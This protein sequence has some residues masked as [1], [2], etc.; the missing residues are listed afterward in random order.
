[1][2]VPTTPEGLPLDDRSNAIKIPLIVLIIFSS[3]FVAIRLGINWRNRN[4]FLLTDHLLWTGHV[5]AIAGGACCYKMAEYGGGKHVWDPFMTPPRLEKQLYY[6]WLS[7]ILNLYGM[8]LVKLSVCAYIFMLD[9]SKTFRVMIWISIVVHVGVNFVFPTVILFGE[10]TPYSK[11]WDVAGT[12]PGSCWGPEPRVISGYS[13]A[14]V[15]IA[16]DLLYTMAPLVYISRI[17]LSKRTIW[18]VRAVFLC[19]LVTTTISALKLYEMKALANTK[20]PSFESVNLSIFASAE[21]FVGAFTASLPPLR[22]TFENFLRRILP[23]SLTGSSGKGSKA[24]RQSYMLD[25]I[26]ARSTAKSWPGKQETDGDSELGILPNEEAARPT[27][28]SDQAI[29]KTTN[30]TVTEDDRSLHL[31]I[32]SHLTSTPPPLHK[33]IPVTM[34]TSTLTPYTLDLSHRG[35]AQGRTYHDAQTGHPQCHYFGGIPYALPAARFQRA[36]PLPP[37]YRYGTQSQPGV[38]DGACGLCPQPASGPGKEDQV[39][40]EDCLQCN[41]WVPVGEAPEG[42]GGF[43]QWGSPNGLNL[44]LLLSNSPTRCIVVAPAYRLNVFGF[45]GSRHL[46]HDDNDEDNNNNSGCADYDANVGFWDQRLA[47]QWTHENIA[48]F[49][50]DAAN[51]TVGGYSAG[52]HSVFHQLSYDLGLG[53]G[54]AVVRRAMMLSNGPGMQPKSLDEA[55]EQFEELVRGLGIE[56]GLGPAEALARLRKVPAKEIVEASKKMGLHQ[57]RAVTDGVFVRQGLLEELSN[58]VYA[59]RLRRRNIHLIIGECKDEHFMYG[60]WR[61]PQPGY[62]NMLHRLEADYPRKACKVLMSHYFP[63]R[64]LP[65]RFKSWQEAFG[66]IYADVQIHALRRGMVNAL[67][68]HGAGNLIHRYRIEWR[69]RCVDKELPSHFGVTHGSDIPIWFWGNGSDLTEEEKHIAAQTFHHPLTKFLKGEDMEWGTEHA[70]Q[71][72]TLKSDGRVVIEEDT[73]M[74]EGLR[75][76]DALKKVGATGEPKASA[77]L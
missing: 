44:R 18:G 34:S 60:T 15:N 45:L 52:S 19:G 57:F 35:Y 11:H 75:L 12:K 8:A 50:G 68:E 38:F 59:E 49:G 7:Q 20:D 26:E 24:S 53:E 16:T 56:D 17:Q 72:R 65:S 64:K 13:G 3:V 25:N 37:C 69:A 77:R 47:L 43:L 63:D 36:N 62:T 54:K 33:P 48:Y 55:Q 22:K 61:P 1:M 21:V 46:H 58:G 30:V 74:E 31:S 70:M 76:W 28:N 51:I 9:F 4:F 41:V 6:V 73:R 23:A 27:T 5:V 71:L 10:C 40:D 67:A 66:H 42:D 39:G 14:A 29:T 32:T 2:A